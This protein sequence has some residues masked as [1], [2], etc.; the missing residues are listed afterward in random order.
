MGGG[1]GIMASTGFF[2]SETNAKMPAISIKIPATNS[3]QKPKDKKERRPFSS[4]IDIMTKTIGEIILNIP[5]T[6]SI[7]GENI[8]LCLVI[9]MLPINPR[10]S[11]RMSNMPVANPRYVCGVRNRVTKKYHMGRCVFCPDTQGRKMQRKARIV[12]IRPIVT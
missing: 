11:P 7:I 8:P 1:G 5:P 12:E 3:S 2:L 10:F 4:T 6:R 9:V